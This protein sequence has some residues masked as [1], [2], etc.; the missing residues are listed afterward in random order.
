MD[1]PLCRKNRLIAYCELQRPQ[2]C[3]ERAAH[4]R[5]PEE[6]RFRALAARER[7]GARLSCWSTSLVECTGPK[8][9]AWLRSPGRCRDG[10]RSSRI[11]PVVPRFG[12]RHGKRA[13][14]LG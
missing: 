4:S 8:L 1:S 7:V 13:L 9:I 5:V 14:V 10:G 11:T 3:P 6:V 12:H 2:W